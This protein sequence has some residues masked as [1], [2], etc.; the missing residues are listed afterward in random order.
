[1]S[2]NWD[3]PTEL[4]ERAQNARAQ[5]DRE[6]A[7]QLY[8]RASELNPQDAKAWQ[9]RAETATSTD[10]ELVSYAYAAALDPM[11]QELTRTLDATLT[12]RTQTTA[13]TDAP[14]LVAMGQELAEV[15]LND[16][17]RKLFA[18]ATELDSNS[19]DALVWLAGVAPD[20]QTQLDY[21]NRALAVNSRDPRARAGLLS[22]KLPAPPASPSVSSQNATAKTSEP[23]AP[24][25][26]DSASME[27]L[28]KL[29]ANVP[30][31]ETRPITPDAPPA[32]EFSAS[33]P[34]KDNR[35]RNIVLILLAIVVLLALAGFFL[36]MQ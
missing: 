18:R 6:L 17:A 34:P 19:S 36:Q 26:G 13:F 2:S 32:Q 23:S 8:A 9:A 3:N 25:N 12:Q 14:L 27:R 5:G 30:A 24:T 31:N 11:N 1:M 22:V 28:R 21:L 33:S 7:Y 4:Y 29:R 20:D 35:M 10:E 15:G 16:H